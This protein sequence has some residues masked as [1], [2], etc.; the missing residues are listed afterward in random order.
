MTA[1]NV[2]IKNA[3]STSSPPSNTDASSGSLRKDS[4]QQSALYQVLLSQQRHNHSDVDD[5]RQGALQSQ[6]PIKKE[7]NNKL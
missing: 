1:T 6:T 5:Q 4:G 2:R 7:E 3:L